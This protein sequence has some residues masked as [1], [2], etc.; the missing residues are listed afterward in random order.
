MGK[1]CARC[2]SFEALA[3]VD[4]SEEPPIVYL[5]CQNCNREFMN[6]E[7]ILANEYLD[8]CWAVDSDYEDL[9][10]EIN[11]EDGG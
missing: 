3:Q 10:D 7:L 6:K 11:E 9:R 2:N 5:Q 4:C 8:K 1:F